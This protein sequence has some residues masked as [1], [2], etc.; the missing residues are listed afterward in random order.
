MGVKA[1][2]FDLDN[3][4]IDFLRYKE[5]ACA[6]AVDAI[7]DAGL[8]IGRGKALKEIYKIYDKF[9]IEDHMIFQKFLMKV[10]GKVDYRQLAYAINAYRMARISMLYPY[11][12]TRRTLIKLRERGLKLAIVSDAPK[13]KAW[14][15]LTSMRLDTFFD[16]V[17]ALD[18]TGRQKPSRLPFRA[19]LKELEVKPEE[20]IMVGD[21]L[22][23]DVKGGRALGMKTCFAEY[24]YIGKKSKIKAD[25]SLDSVED[26]VK[27]VDSLNEEE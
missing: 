8:K 17:I 5:V 11:P 6:K 2:L 14:V 22:S 9:G 20:C 24:G 18:D 19:A 23:R 13:L 3:T 26:I 25:Y 15:R 7:I 4:L 12:G 10:S 21:M 16:T 1:V 27:V